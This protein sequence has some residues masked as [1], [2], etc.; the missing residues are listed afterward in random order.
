MCWR[1]SVRCLPSSLLPPNPSSLSSLSHHQLHR[2]VVLIGARPHIH[3]DGGADADGGDGEVRHNQV[4]GSAREREQLCVGGGDGGQQGPRSQRVQV[5]RQ[6]AHTRLQGVI[7]GERVSKLGAVGCSGCCCMFPPINIMHNLQRAR[8]FLHRPI[9]RPAR[10]A[11]PHPAAPLRC[12]F[13]RGRARGALGARRAQRAQRPLPF[14]GR[15]QRPG[16]R[17]ADA[18]QCGQGGLE[19]AHVEHGQ[20]E[21]DVAKVAGAVGQREAARR[22]RGRL[23]GDAEAGV[24][25]AVGGGFAVGD[26]CVGWVSACACEVRPPPR[27]FPFHPLSLPLLTYIIQLAFVHLQLGRLH[28][29]A[30]R[31]DAKADAFAGGGV[32]GRFFSVARRKRGRHRSPL[33]P[34]A[35]GR[36]PLP[37]LRSLTQSPI[38]L[39][40]HAA[41]HVGRHVRRVLGRRRRVGAAAVAGRAALH[42]GGRGVR[43]RDGATPLE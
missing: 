29:L 16:T 7:G 41:R 42:L 27:P 23:G 38:P 20:R 10:R 26:L 13:Q 32:E 15:Q 30:G 35:G 43:A 24:Q 2:D 36:G 9:G 22:T 8:H 21:P 39:H 1:A 33:V 18:L 19:V 4:H 37:S 5:V 6:A 25:H 40:S 28:D 17:L 11:R 14:I 12:A 3:L 31:H 34:P